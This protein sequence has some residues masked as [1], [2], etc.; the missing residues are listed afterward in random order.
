MSFTVGEKNGATYKMAAEASE[1]KH[2]IIR[3][4]FAV[5]TKI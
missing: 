1:I 3:S 4:Y 2:A 5:I